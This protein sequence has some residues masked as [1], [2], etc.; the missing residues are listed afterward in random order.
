MTPALLLPMLLAAAPTGDDLV[1][2]TTVDGVHVH[3]FVPAEVKVLRGL[4]VH[5][6]NTKFKTGDRWSEAGRAIGFGHLVL[7][8]ADVRKQGNRPVRLRK[9]LDEGLREFAGKSGRK[10]LVHLPMIGVGHSAGGL[11]S[12]VLLKTPERTAA[13]CV[14]CGWITATAKLN[15]ATDKS[16]PFLFTLG[17]IP[18]AF[19]MLPGIEANYL[20]ARKD[21]WPWGLGL[22][23]GCAHDFGN[24]ATLMIAWSEAVAAARIPADADA[25]A[26]PPAL[27]E[28]RLEDGWL[29]D[30]DTIKTTAPVIAAW[31]DYTGDRSRAVWL[32]DR[33]AAMVWRAWQ[34]KEPPVQMNA[35]AA[36]GSARMPAWKPKI[37][38]DLMVSPGVDVVLSVAP[39]A[40]A[41][42]RKVRYF[43]RDRLV[44]EGDASAEFRFTWKSPTAGAHPV[45]AE[46]ETA[47]GKT[48]VTNPGLV[49]VRR[50]AKSG[51][52]M[53]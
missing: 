16:V 37:S 15:A 42:V 11:V 2:H 9:A 4:Y 45:Y 26:G 50:A 13:L 8:M 1:F 23:W 32:P 36:D 35:E 22:Q 14:D 33:G 39:E 48:G 44:G 51:D 28:I 43:D 40:G 47:D 46:W 25:S 24:A 12:P 38:R 31:A 53:R 29:G 34:A 49:I 41:E 17:A 7:D 27:R 5:A 18:D 10:E 3:L 21:G 30:H 52:T 19:K 6:A 20:P